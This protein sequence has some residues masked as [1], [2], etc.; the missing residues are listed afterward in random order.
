MMAFL[1]LAAGLAL[2]FFLPVTLPLVSAKYISVL[3]LVTL[4]AVLGGA[5]AQAEGRLDA[6]DLLLGFFTNGV[7]AALL[8]LAG[9]RIGI[10][11]Y[12]V[13]LL[14]FGL[15]IFK[16]LARLRHHFLQRRRAAGKNF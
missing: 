10:D 1:G 8:V 5:R 13:A 7:L 14:A 12:Y 9:D 6:A 16:N 3:L 11:L 15:R 4:D 2:G